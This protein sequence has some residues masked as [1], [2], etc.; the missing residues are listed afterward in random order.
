MPQ[1]TF[2]HFGGIPDVE[3]LPSFSSLGKLRYLTLAILNSLKEFPSFEGLSKLTALNIVEATRAKTL[4]SLTP[5]V[6]LKSLGLRYRTGVCCNGYLTGTCDT[7]SFQCVPKDGEKYP[8]T[9]TTDRASNEDKAILNMNGETEICPNSF[10]YDLESAAPTKYTSDDLCGSVL[11]KNC[12]LNGVQGICYNTRMMVI[13]CVTQPAYITMRQLQIERKVGKPCNVTEEDWLGCTLAPY[14]DDERVVYYDLETDSHS[15][16]LMLSPDAVSAPAQPRVATTTATKAAGEGGGS[17][18]FPRQQQPLFNLDDSGDEAEGEDENPFATLLQQQQQTQQTATL[19]AEADEAACRISWEFAR[20]VVATTKEE[21]GRGAIGRGGTRIGNINGG[22]RRSILKHSHQRSVMATRVGTGAKAKKLGFE[23]AGSRPIDGARGNLHLL[24]PKTAAIVDC[25]V[26]VVDGADANVDENR[27]QRAY[28][29]HK[30]RKTDLVWTVTSTLVLQPRKR[31][32]CQMCCNAQRHC[33]SSKTRPTRILILTGQ[34]DEN[35]TEAD[36]IL[37]TE[38]QMRAEPFA[39]QIFSPTKPVG[40]GIG[41]KSKDESIISKIRGS[42]GDLFVSAT[43]TSRSCVR[44]PAFTT[45]TEQ[46]FLTE[47][48]DWRHGINSR[49]SVHYGSSHAALRSYATFCFVRM[50]NPRGCSN[51]GENYCKCVEREELDS[52]SI[53][54]PQAAEYLKLSIGTSLKIYE[55]L[56]FV[57]EEVAVGSTS[58]P[59]WFLLSTQLTEV[60]ATSDDSHPYAD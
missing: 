29:G 36:A 39:P 45:S 48:C 28:Q 18:V 19:A 42:M 35:P 14:E 30:R 26:V 41:R 58:K 2:I 53:F 16:D 54:H 55:P 31:D 25:G 5:L 32:C 4:P 50:S 33:H 24:I 57:E 10:A 40:G 3:E 49:P 34:V 23:A 22:N 7:I 37:D 17:Q 9:C 20:A 6:S 51:A 21:T 56:R 60:V 27:C 46:P 52:K 11:Y 1:L 38:H 8:M 12:T 47:R 43:E 59:E 44:R 13:C 15:R